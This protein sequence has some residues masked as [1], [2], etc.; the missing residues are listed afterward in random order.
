MVHF[1]KCVLTTRLRNCLR[2][3]KQFFSATQCKIP[4]IFKYLDYHAL[5]KVARWV[6]SREAGLNWNSHGIWYFQSLRRVVDKMS[7]NR[8]KIR[9]VLVTHLCT[10][11]RFERDL[12]VI[13]HVW[14][15]FCNGSITWTNRTQNEVSNSVEKVVPRHLTKPAPVITDNGFAAFRVPDHDEEIIM[16]TER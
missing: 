8:I 5:R 1:R 3:P 12:K 15:I 16:N 10:T 9:D 14:V 2:N 13:R 11:E 7:V 4:I 6:K